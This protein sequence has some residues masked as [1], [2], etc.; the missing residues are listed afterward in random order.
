M[1][2]PRWISSCC[3]FGCA[4]LWLSMPASAQVWTGPAG[5]E[6]RVDDERG[7]AVEGAE[8]VLSYGDQTERPAPVLTDPRGRAAIGGLAGGLWSVEVRHQGHMTFRATFLLVADKK[9]TIES[10]AQH[11]VPGAVAPMRVRLD[12]AKSAPPARPM[13]QSVAPPPSEPVPTPTPAPPPP[14]SIATPAPPP[15]SQPVPTPTPAPPP[16]RSTATPA[17]PPP[18]EPVATPTPA[19]PPPRSAATP[20]PPPPSEPVATPTPAP[21]PPRS[22]ATPAPPPPSEPVATLAPAPPPPRSASTPAPPPPAPS[23]PL[24]PPAQMP[25]VQRTCYECSPGEQALF[26][27]VRLSTSGGCGEE[28]RSLLAGAARAEVESFLGRPL[29]AGCSVLR[30]DVPKGMR[31][32]GFRYEAGAPGARSAD[33]F[34]DRPCSA[35]GCRFVGDPILRRDGESTTVLVIFEVDGPEPRTG[36]LSVYYSAARRR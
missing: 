18:S 26:T 13:I 3:M 24:V 29:P 21:P 16:P 14:R 28:L 23:A 17:P 15:P 33:C 19:P 12:R 34:P 27:E 9:P 36:G 25:P 32:L 10:A 6:V 4:W 2:V 8:V 35:G 22:A 30:V 1:R 20:A 31:Y 5:L 7:R 11:N